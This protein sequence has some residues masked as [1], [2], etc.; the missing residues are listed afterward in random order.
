MQLWSFATAFVAFA[1]T[2]LGQQVA[3]LPGTQALTVEGDLSA[4]MVQG[5]DH[6]LMRKIDDSVN[7]R[8]VLWRRDFSST[9]AYEK[10]I[11]PNRE[12]LGN[13]IGAVDPRVHFK[14]LDYLSST[15]V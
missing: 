13:A 5:I 12:R 4:Q 3:N 7:E 15:A 6:F 14:A 1:S 9:E 2:L 11:G 8:A 10:S